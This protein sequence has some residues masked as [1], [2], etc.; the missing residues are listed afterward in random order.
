MAELESVD[1]EAQVEFFAFHAAG[2]GHGEMAQLVNEDHK[3]QGERHFH[4]DQRG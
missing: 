1:V 4:N 2:F 3:T